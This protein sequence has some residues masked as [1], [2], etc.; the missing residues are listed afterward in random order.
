MTERKRS[1]V[2]RAWALSDIIPNQ[3]V[4]GEGHHQGTE[5]A[6]NRQLTGTALATEA[7]ATDVGT[8]GDAPH[9][10]ASWLSHRG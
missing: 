2:M 6:S 8:R 10:W 4:V 1:R 7:L 5:Q 9:E 3:R